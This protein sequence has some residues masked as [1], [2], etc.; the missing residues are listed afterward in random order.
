[1]QERVVMRPNRKHRGVL[2][3]GGEFWVLGCLHKTLP[4]AQTLPANSSLS[5]TEVTYGI[6]EVSVA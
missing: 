2:G 4:Q 1:M 3:L 5:Y 6:N